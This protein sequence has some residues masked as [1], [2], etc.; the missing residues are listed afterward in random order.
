[1]IAPHRARSANWCQAKHIE[2]HQALLPVAE[3]VTD[4]RNEV[5]V[6]RL[7]GDTMRN[8]DRIIF[9]AQALKQHYLM[10]VEMANH[11]PTPAAWAT[12]QVT[13]GAISDPT[14]DIA[15]SSRRQLAQRRLAHVRKEIRAASLGLES[16][17]VTTGLIIEQSE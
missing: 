12:E 8:I 9:N 6:N 1:V 4:Q 7:D 14:A 15:L 5:A 16:A 10:S 17:S 2:T 11:I 13:N 3:K